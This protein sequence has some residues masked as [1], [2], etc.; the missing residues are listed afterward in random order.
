MRQYTRM[1]RSG[2]SPFDMMEWEE[3]L[4]Y[5]FRGQLVGQD[6]DKLMLF[7]LDEPEMVKVEEIVLPS[8]EQ[9]EEGKPSSRRFISS[10]QNGQVLWKADHKYCTGRDFT[11]GALLW[12]LGCTSAGSRDRRNEHFYRRW[13]ECSAP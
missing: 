3:G 13:P 9:D 10:H 12:K 5:R 1:P 8:K 11:A 2:K 6:D 7:E 4:K